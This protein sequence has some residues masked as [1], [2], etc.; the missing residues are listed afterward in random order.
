MILYLE[1][2]NGYQRLAAVDAQS[3]AFL[4]RRQ[5][6]GEFAALAA[7]KRKFGL[8]KRPP[9]AVVASVFPEGSPDVSWST[10]RAAVA[11]ANA[12]AFAWGVPAAGLMVDGL[13][14]PSLAAA[15]RAA[16][17]SAKP[18]ARLSAKYNGE[19]NI[20]KAKAQ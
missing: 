4:T 10:V 11:V 13:D 17:K 12:L 8:A 9:A 1:F 18:D 20:T 6:R 15:V 2:R 16:A 19:P 7:A 3:A 5:D 14:E